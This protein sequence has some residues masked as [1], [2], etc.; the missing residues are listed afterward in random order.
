[1]VYQNPNHAQAVATQHVKIDLAEKNLTAIRELRV[2]AEER[3][4]EF[5]RTFAPRRLKLR[6]ARDDEGIRALEREHA[7]VKEAVQGVLADIAQ[8]ETELR[9][10][11]DALRRIE[12][13]DLI[14]RAARQATKF[15]GKVREM[16]AQLK[17]LADLFREAWAERIKLVQGWPGGATESFNHPAYAEGGLIR[18]QD[19]VRTV[20]AAMYRY[21]GVQFISATHNAL[22]PPSFPGSKTK[23]VLKFSPADNPT[24]TEAADHAEQYL[25]AIL[26]GKP[27]PAPK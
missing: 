15:T 26:Q 21:G 23:H 11:K 19:L 1:M 25:T 10:A 9:E 4:A 16:D 2:P 17:A 13:A 27:W 20:R 22:L 7:D 3:Q 14:K 5:E 8:A 6:L 24:L 18:A 12:H